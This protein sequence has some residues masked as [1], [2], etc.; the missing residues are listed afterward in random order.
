M[1]KRIVYHKLVNHIQSMISSGNYRPGDRL[2]SLR[3]LA[4]NFN[5]S[6][7]AAFNGMRRLLESGLIESR[8]GSGMFVANPEGG[9]LPPSRGELLI[10]LDNLANGE[11][12]V[13]YGEYAMR[14][15]RQSA[16]NYGFTVRMNFCEY[17]H[18]KLKH[19]GEREL[20]AGDAAILLGSF[21]ATG[22]ELPLQIPTVGMTMQNIWHRRMSIVDLDPYLAAQ[23]ACKY[24]RERQISE[25]LLVSSPFSAPALRAAAFR[26]LFRNQGEVIEIQVGFD[27]NQDISYLD[28]HNHHGVLFTS[29]SFCEFA[30]RNYALK[31]SQDLRKERTILSI[32]GKSRYVKNYHPVDTL[33][34]DWFEAGTAIFEESWRLLQQPQSGSRRIYLATEFIPAE[35]PIPSEQ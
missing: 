34:P 20:N 3:I 23:Q 33:S 12:G 28:H 22:E 2:P 15:I 13:S 26:E 21:D 6:R 17:H 19:S 24:F 30:I 18:D 16:R 9:I 25:V 11:P 27:C 14:G 8:H 4:E 1:D 7:N 35:T 5:I 32:D 29:G 31:N 10:V